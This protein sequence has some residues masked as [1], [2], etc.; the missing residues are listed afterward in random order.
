MKDTERE[1]DNSSVLWL[2]ATRTWH[3]LYSHFLF[4]SL[5]TDLLQSEEDWKVRGGDCGWYSM[6]TKADG[7]DRPLMNNETDT[8]GYDKSDYESAPTSK[9]IELATTD[10][11]G[12]STARLSRRSSVLVRP[13]FGLNWYT[14][15]AGGH[16]GSLPAFFQRSRPS[17]HHE[18]QVHE[19]RRRVSQVEMFGKTT[20]FHQLL[21]IGADS[22]S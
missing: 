3:K 9:S 13:F 16:L 21:I 12:E 2:I 20:L 18:H 1:H 5:W 6:P 14:K 4:V 11:E 10:D 7:A 22:H 19:R 15:W 8:D 17:Q